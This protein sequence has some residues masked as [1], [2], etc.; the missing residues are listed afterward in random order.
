MS[1]LEAVSERDKILTAMA[2]NHRVYL[3][4][5]RA[6]AREIALRKGEVSIDDVRT[7]VER[8][9]FPMPRDIGADERILGSLFKT[10]EFFPIGM[11]RTTRDAWAARVGRS[12]DAV[13]VYRL[14]ERVA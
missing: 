1:F 4:S 7:E 2:A 14:S 10:K 13:T 11:R 9:A 5:L 12:R 3:E 8:R 6:F